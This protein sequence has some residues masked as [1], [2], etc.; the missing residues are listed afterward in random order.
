[1][2]SIISCILAAQCV[3]LLALLFVGRRLKRLQSFEK[4]SISQRADAQWPRV[5][6]IVPVGGNSPHMTSALTSLLTQDYPDYLPVFV[7]E[8]A[9]EPAAA[10]IRKLQNDFPALRHVVAGH[11]KRCGQKNHNTLA[12]VASITN[13]KID[14]LTFCD[15]THLATPDFLRL[16]VAPI[17]EGKSDFSTGYHCV[18]HFDEKWTTLAYTASVLL[19][20]L[21]QGLSR[22]TQPWGGAMAIRY[23]AFKREQVDILWAS[24]VVDDCSLAALLLQRK[25]PVSL[26]AAALLRTV[27]R[28]HPIRVWQDWM[29]RQILFLKF[30]IPAQWKLLGVLVVCMAFPPIFA[31]VAFLGGLFGIGT[32]AAVALSLCWLA[33]FWCEM[34]YL[35]GL[36]EKDCSHI[37]FVG[38]FLLACGMFAKVYVGT[39]RAHSIIWQGK[40]YHVGDNGKIV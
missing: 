25:I 31:S 15:S 40:E 30:C 8:S 4:N 14:I 32:G 28:E 22:F 18:E 2:L 37:R 20:R 39:I 5:A 19:M 11:A 36:L 17:S 9:D 1:M 35:R 38:A 16:L 23:T 7:T 3:I 27:A 26:C 34:S 10:C 24:S 6:M 29:E 21:L 12:G 33:C 13:E